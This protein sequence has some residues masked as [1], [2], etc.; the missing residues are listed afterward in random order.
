MPSPCESCSATRPDDVLICRRCVSAL[1]RDLEAVPDLVADLW[2]TLT[3]QDRLTAPGASRGGGSPLPWNDHARAALNRLTREVCRWGDHGDPR[4]ASES[5]VERLPSLAASEWT[6]DNAQRLSGAVSEAR[7][8]IDVPDEIT[9]FRVGPCPLPDGDHACPG[10]VW[11]HLPRDGGAYL[12]CRTGEA[13]HW[14]AERWLR[15]GRLI[16]RRVADIERA[17]RAAALNEMAPA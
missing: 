14:P 5:L 1:R 4:A 10:T 12:Q 6:P 7:R 2:L 16:A 9:R 11:A 15:A 3:R 17:R 8:V 13:H